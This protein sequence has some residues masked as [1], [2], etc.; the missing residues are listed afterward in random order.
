MSTSMSMSV[1]TRVENLDPRV[2][3]IFNDIMENY[4]AGMLSFLEKCES[5]IEQL[6]MLALN[7]E[8]ENYTL[9]TDDGMIII[10]PQAEINIGGSDGGKIKES[11]RVD[12]LVIIKIKGKFIRVIVECDGHEFHEKTREQAIRDKRR[13]R[14]LILE[15]YIVLNYTGSEIWSNPFKCAR[16]VLELMFRNGGAM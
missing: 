2:R 9:L 1:S 7:S 15:G 16:E 6:M 8:K 11:F 4:A 14:L 3:Q 5:P 13:G 12:F 10:H